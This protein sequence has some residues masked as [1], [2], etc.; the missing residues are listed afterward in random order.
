MSIL[1]G[2]VLSFRGVVPSDDNTVWRVSVLVVV[3]AKP[4][5]LTVDGAV[6]AAPEV[7]WSLGNKRVVRYDASVPLAATERRIKYDLGAGLPTWEFTVPAMD[8][9]PRMA[10]VSCNGFSSADGMKRLPTPAN[11]MWED[12]L[13][14]HDKDFRASGYVIDSEQRWHEERSHAKGLQRFHLLMM[15]G[16]QI[17]FDSIWEE[18]PLLKDWVS[19]SWDDQ[20]KFKPDATL[21]SEIEDYYFN[22]YVR[23]WSLGTGKTWGPKFTDHKLAAAAMASIPTIM[24]WD[25]HDIFDGWGSYSSQLQLC[26]LFEALFDSARRAFWVFQMQHREAD[27]PKLTHRNGKPSGKSYDPDFV[28]IDWSKQLAKDALHLPLIDGQPAFSSAFILGPVA[29]VVLDLRTERSKDQVMGAYTWDRF[30]RILQDTVALKDRGVQHL[31]ILSS[32]PVAH[33]KISLAESALDMFGSDHV[34][35]SNADDISDHWSHDRHD[36]ERK[37]LIRTLIKA[38]RVQN[39]RVSIVS[40]D[41]HVAAWGSIFRK[42]ATPGSNQLRIHQF[43]STAIVHPSL[44]SFFERLFLGIMNRVATQPQPIDTEH[45]VE[46]MLFPGSSDRVYAARN[47]LALE[48]DA[49]VSAEFGGRRLWATWRCEGSVRS[50]NHLVAVHPSKGLPAPAGIAAPVV[51]PVVAPV[52]APAV[53]FAPVP[54]SPTT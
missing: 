38:A 30:T 22:L 42:D 40:G 33:P 18:L 26:P 3:D 43:T 52:A 21:V 20:V 32:V 51:Q 15:G 27:L 11:A 19:L 28:E 24:M 5:Q 39:L 29:L 37:R 31:L 4:P 46:M 23:R 49:V 12:L 48:P 17:Y 13:C 53:A 50:T 9:V 8:V 25:D 36:G 54:G 44:T 16:D 2:P 14:N 10:Y 6:A 45:S 47:W 1:M 7:L 34:T 35:K 41:V